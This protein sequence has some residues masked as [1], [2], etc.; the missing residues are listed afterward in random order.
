MN[1]ITLTQKKEQLK[2]IIA[3]YMLSNDVSAE[4]ARMLNRLSEIVD[5]ISVENIKEI[6]GLITYFILDS[7]D[8]KNF[9]V[10]EFLN[11]DKLLKS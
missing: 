11:F 4:E 10:E 8:V 2:Q 5:E 7:F 9:S 3:D 1:S 6:A